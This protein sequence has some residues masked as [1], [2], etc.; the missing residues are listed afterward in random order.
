MNGRRHLARSVVLAGLATVFVTAVGAY[1]TCVPIDPE[2][3]ECHTN[4]DCGLDD[5][6]AP[7]LQYCAKNAG[8]CDGAGVCEDRPE[9][10]YQIYAPVCGC[11]GNTYPN[12]CDAA[13]AGA[14]VAYEG[15]C[16]QPVSPCERHGGICVSPEN[17][18]MVCPAGFE[19]ADFA[20]GDDPTTSGYQ[21]CCVP[22]PPAQCACNADCS[23]RE[24]CIDGMCGPPCEL[25]CFVYEPVCGADGRTYGC[26]EADA[27]CHGVPVLHVGECAPVCDSAT[28]CAPGTTCSRWLVHDAPRSTRS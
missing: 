23:N 8:Q 28:P 5:S 17:G 11:D 27:A 15:P 2:P 26:G 10:C 18:M 14:N 3:I 25:D 13:A 6:G 7:L 12:D 24:V 1:A 4:I 9:G 19:P 20:C 21:L 16:E 22:A